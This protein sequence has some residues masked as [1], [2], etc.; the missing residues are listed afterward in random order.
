M[1]GP[2]TSD[3]PF[4]RVLAVY[5]TETG[6]T[7]VEA[8]KITEA[9]EKD[10]L[11]CELLEGNDAADVFDTIKPDKY[12]LVVVLTSSYGDGDPPSGYGKF[13]FKLYEAAKAGEKALNGLEHAVLGFGS[14]A[15]YTFQNVPRL[16]DRL[17]EESGSRRCLMRTEIDEMDEL[18]DNEKKMEEWKNAILEHLNKRGEKDT[19]KDASVCK[20]TEPKSEVYEKRLGPDGYELGSGPSSGA[21]T[22]VVGV[23]GA[24]IAYFAYNHYV[25]QEAAAN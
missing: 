17:L 21:S 18:E 3:K 25:S 13:L 24:V 14:T 11:K 16:T 23:A 4:G 7:K 8:K 6:M 10:G 20:W 22:L 2:S 19:V 15:Y 12:D 1:C 9:W 5:G